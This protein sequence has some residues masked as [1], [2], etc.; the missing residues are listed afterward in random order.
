MPH[1]D[2][3]PTFLPLTVAVTRSAATGLTG[4]AASGPAGRPGAHAVRRRAE[5]ANTTAAGCWMALLGGCESPE[6]RDMPARLRALAESISLYVGTRWWCGHGAAHRRRV[7]ET[8]LRIHD[9][10]REGD[11]AEFAEAFVGYD[12][13]IAT[14]MVSVPSRLENP[15]P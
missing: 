12:Q 6:R 13:A 7:A 15:I 14:A 11:G 2:Q 5:E 8:Q 10:V 9:A 1:P 4:I 3:E